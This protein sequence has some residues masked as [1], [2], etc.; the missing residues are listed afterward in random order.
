MGE[1]IKSQLRDYWKNFKKI[2]PRKSLEDGKNRTRSWAMTLK[3]E[4][5]LDSDMD[6]NWESLVDQYLAELESEW[7]EW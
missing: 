7:Q 5:K 4:I 3:N 2:F 1:E 6:K